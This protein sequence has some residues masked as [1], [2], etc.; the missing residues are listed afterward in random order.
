MNTTKTP[1]VSGNSALH[2]LYVLGG[3]ACAIGLLVTIIASF[4]SV[5]TNPYSG[6]VQANPTAALFELL[7]FGIALVGGIAVVGGMIAQAVN[8]QIANA[9]GMPPKTYRAYQ[10]EKRGD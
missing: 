6:T 7:G 2:Y 3:L 1:Q 5:T 4:N 9:L 10:E 8:W